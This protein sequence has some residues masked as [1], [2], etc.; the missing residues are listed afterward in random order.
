MYG[1][2]VTINATQTRH[3]QQATPV[4]MLVDEGASTTTGK[5]RY[6]AIL[7]DNLE[8]PTRFVRVKL[9]SDEI[10]GTIRQLANSEADAIYQ[11]YW[12]GA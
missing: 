1:Q 4:A 5:M 10:A 6:E 2:L 11:Q 3:N 7:L 8:A 12:Q 9:Y